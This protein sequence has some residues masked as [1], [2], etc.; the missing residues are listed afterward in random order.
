MYEACNYEDNERNV[1]FCLFLFVFF[2]F[3]LERNVVTQ[4][5]AAAAPPHP[6]P[7]PLFFTLGQLV[8]LRS[9]PA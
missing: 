3:Y 8:I 4:K 7:P 9:E 6:P 1:I 2:I 5:S